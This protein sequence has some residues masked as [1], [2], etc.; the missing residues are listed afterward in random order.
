MHH[1]GLKQLCDPKVDEVQEQKIDEVIEYFK[2][3]LESYDDVR[4]GLHDRPFKDE[5]GVI[6]Q[7]S[8]VNE[9]GEEPRR[10]RK[11]LDRLDVLCRLEVIE[12]VNVEELIR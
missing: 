11:T 2:T 3:L 4:T 9:E 1:F 6:D 12:D 8:D 10:N 7:P 5:Y